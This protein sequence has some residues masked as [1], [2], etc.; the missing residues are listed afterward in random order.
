[1]DRECF[2]E[3][4]DSFA[5]GRGCGLRP[6]LQ[7]VD[8][9]AFAAGRF[10]ELRQQRRR[11]PKS[12]DL[13]TEGE[14]G[15]YVA[16]ARDACGVQV[17]QSPCEQDR[18]WPTGGNADGARLVEDVLRASPDRSVN[19]DRRRLVC[20]S[21][22]RGWNSGLTSSLFG[23]V[24]LGAFARACL[25]ASTGAALSCQWALRAPGFVATG[26]GVAHIGALVGK[27]AGGASAASLRRT[28]RRDGEPH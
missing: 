21:R 2:D 20:L 10:G 26:L 7:H 18:H 25:L 28:A 17:S 22:H 8:V 12:L 3:G 27:V 24:S 14:K 4:C 23:S 6:S 15:P 1:M 5:T 9:I 11:L 13:I 19:A 16:F